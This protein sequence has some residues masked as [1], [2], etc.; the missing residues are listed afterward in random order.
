MALTKSLGK[1]LAATGIR[2]NC[3]T[4]AMI[5][6]ELANT[7]SPERIATALSRTRWVARVCPRK[8]RR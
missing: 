3:V 4:P 2:V 7:M 6:T 8:W 1:E 5:A